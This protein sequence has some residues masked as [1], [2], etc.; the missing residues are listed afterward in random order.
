MRRPVSLW[1]CLFKCLINR[2]LNKEITEGL[3]IDAYMVAITKLT[4]RCGRPHSVIRDNGTIL[5]RA[6]PEFKECFKEWNWD[7]MCEWLALGSNIWKFNYP[8]APHFGRSLE[9][10]LRSCKKAMFA[11]PGNWR[12]MLP[13]LTTTISLVEQLSNARH[14]TSVIDDHEHLQKLVLN[15]FLLRQPVVAKPLM[16]DPA[17]FIDCRKMYKVVQEYN[18]MIRNRRAKEYL[19]QWNVRP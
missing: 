8:G 12:L 19:P 15:H 4:A 18:Q 1:W 11:I 5:V 7:A 13:V 14:L 3:N 16:P 9:R 17:R 10:L 2:A 6:A